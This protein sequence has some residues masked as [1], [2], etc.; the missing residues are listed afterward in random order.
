MV[1][2][3]GGIPPDA[4]K[5][6]LP[7]RIQSFLFMVLAFRVGLLANYIIQKSE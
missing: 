3:M 1:L 2:K 4:G 6:G 5:S 7:P